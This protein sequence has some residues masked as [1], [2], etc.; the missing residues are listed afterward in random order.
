MGKM[1]CRKCKKATE[2]R[3]LKTSGFL[4]QVF[5]SIVAGQGMGGRE[6]THECLECGRQVISD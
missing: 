6:P 2:W 1:F 5:A 4:F 3:R